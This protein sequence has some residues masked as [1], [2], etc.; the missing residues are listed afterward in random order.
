MDQVF[1]NLLVV[2]DTPANL[3]L[4]SVA[5]AAQGYRVRAAPNGEA[6]L[7]M[8][9]EDPPDMV[10]LDINMQGVDGFAVFD[11]MKASPSLANVAVLFISAAHDTTTKLRAFYRGGVDFIQKPFQLEE[12]F[13]RVATH[14]E[15]RR[16]RTRLEAQNEQLSHIVADQVREISDSQIATIVALAKL[17][18]WRDDD[19]GKHIERIGSFATRLAE[20]ACRRGAVDLLEDGL[21]DVIGRA[22]ALH[23]IGKV[24]IPDE[25]L[26]KPARLTAEE[27]VVV[28]RH[29][30]IGYDTLSTVLGSYPGN[31]IVKIGTLIT[32]SHH[33]R[34]DGSGYPDG[35]A[36]ADI[37][38]CARVVAVADVYDALRSRRPYK[39]PMSHE[40]AV[41]IIRESSGSHFDPLIVEAFLD[42]SKSFESVW[43]SMEERGST[44]AGQEHDV[45]HLPPAAAA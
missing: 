12:V 9:L 19:T 41:R 28:R 44:E 38:W 37:P 40:A 8:A 43:Q 3:R 18:E 24:G 45:V 5:L 11:R 39:N 34:W 7:R 16:L 22:A 35:L 4:L 31:E 29:T 17:A 20:A 36:G 42:V 21:I 33:E 14:L 15:L 25:V 1:E 2:D 30:V 10:L 6:A 27:F 13:A 32:R 23:D 26:L